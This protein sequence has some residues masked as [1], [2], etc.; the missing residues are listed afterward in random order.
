[1]DG[2][3]LSAYFIGLLYALGVNDGL[4][5]NILIA[6]LESN[7]ILEGIFSAP[8]IETSYD[9]T[10]RETRTL[11]ENFRSKNYDFNMQFT[12]VSRHFGT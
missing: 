7:E 8:P 6:L 10:L 2:D 12:H 5:G 9:L 11:L 3:S 1:M 4:G